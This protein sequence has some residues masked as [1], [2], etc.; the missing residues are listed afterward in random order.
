MNFGTEIFHSI[1][2]LSDFYNLLGGINFILNSI[3]FIVCIP[4]LVGVVY[5]NAIIN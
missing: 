3:G 5:Y 2:F 1:Y 4:S